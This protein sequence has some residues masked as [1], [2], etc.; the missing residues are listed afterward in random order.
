MQ[1]LDSDFSVLTTVSDVTALTFNTTGAD[2]NPRTIT[3]GN[4]GTFGWYGNLNITGSG[5]FV[6][7]AENSFT[8]A[9]TV[10][11]TATLAINPGKKMTTGAITVAS[12]ATLQVPESGTVTLGG[13]LTLADGAILDF[14]YTDKDSAPAID[15]TGKA[16]TLGEQANV[17]VKAN[18]TRPNSKY[19]PYLLTSGGGFTGANLT[20][21][22]DSAEWVKDISVN[23]DGNIVF[24]VKEAGIFI[25]IR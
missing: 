4:G 19:N 24:N 8:G 12:G 5:R 3:V 9:V 11:D 21:D 13:G 1:P 17:V 15:V 10:N 25:L 16:V 20:L 23:A 18:G 7:D 6:V 2:G 22:A 14:N